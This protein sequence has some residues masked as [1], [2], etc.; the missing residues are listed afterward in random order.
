MTIPLREAG[1]GTA[2]TLTLSYSTPSFD[3]QYVM[4]LGKTSQPRGWFIKGSAKPRQPR[5]DAHVL[6]VH[7]R[8]PKLEIKIPGPLS[9]YYTHESIEIPLQLVNTESETASIKLDTHLF[10][11]TVPSFRIKGVQGEQSADGAEEEAKISGLN[12]G[13]LAS[14]STMDLVLKIDPAEAPTTYDLHLR[15]TYHLESDPATPVKQILPV[16]LVVVS[17]FEANYDLAPRLHLEPWPS[18]FDSDNILGPD[19]LELESAP[20][21]GLSQNWCLVC[22]YASFASEDLR[23]MGMEMKVLSGMNSARYSIVKQP[24]V[25]KGGFAVSPKTMH[26]ARFDLVA[27]K[28]SVDDRNPAALDLAFVIHWKREGAAEDAMANTTTMVAGHFLVLGSEPR[29]LASIFETPETRDTGLMHLDITVENPSSHFLTFGLSMDPSDDFAFSGAK[30]TTVHLLP[31]S[32]RTTTYR[33]LP[34]VTGKFV[35][36]GITVRDKYFQKSLRIIPTEGMKIDKDGLLVWVPPV[37]GAADEE[38]EEE[39]AP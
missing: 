19:E 18:L 28:I 9:Q 27:Q 21:R 36:P 38:E 3:L 7:P 30:Q 34:L 8:P 17:A 1:E 2:S 11:K 33:L 16:Q 29:V 14:S 39:E 20:A 25:P 5:F 37:E 6:Q 15:A 10:G 24:E 4:K 12:L 32:R 35:R 13:S 26:E 22:H 23:I 31:M